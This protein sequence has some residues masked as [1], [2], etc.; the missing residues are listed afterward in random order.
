MHGVES[1]DFNKDIGGGGETAVNE[2]KIAEGGEE[3][4]AT[5]VGGRACGKSV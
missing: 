2:F 3:G 1:G 5:A 4:C